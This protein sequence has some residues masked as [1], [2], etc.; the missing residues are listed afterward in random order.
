MNAAGTNMNCEQYKEA[1]AADPSE[2]FDGG[3]VHSAEC[4]SCNAVKMEMRALDARILAALEINVPQLT[5]PD[6]PSMADEQKVVDLVSRRPSRWSI[7]AWAGLAASI[8][9]ATVIGMRFLNT[10]EDYGTLADQVV[11]HLDYELQSRRVTDVAVSD[12]QLYSVVRPAIATM[13]RNLGL[14]TY[15]KTCSINGREVPHLVMQGERGPITI[16]LMPYE[17]IDMPVEL[18]GESIEGVI[19]PV[20]NGSIAIIGERGAAIEQV[21]TKITEAVKW[22]I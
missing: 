4:S 10:G 8:A 15:A 6:L 21:G 20:G 7:P 11:A 2:S 3:A 22:S 12:Q 18:H 9:L 19:L 16:L 14:I 1:I 17:M 5:M 13:D